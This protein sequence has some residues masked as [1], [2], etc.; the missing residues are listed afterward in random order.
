MRLGPVS[1]VFLDLEKL[2][3]GTG[4]IIGLLQYF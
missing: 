4:P 3:N 1:D 2:K